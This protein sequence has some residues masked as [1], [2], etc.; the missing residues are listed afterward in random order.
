MFSYKNRIKAVKLLIKYD[1]S[2]SDVRREL[3]YPS[4]ESL[5]KWYREYI[6]NGDL[7]SEYIRKDMYS[8]KEKLNAVN[9]YVEHGKSVSRTVRKLGYPSRPILDK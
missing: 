2:Y 6:K 3:G 1:M 4:K 9:Y 7:K 8:E 5:R